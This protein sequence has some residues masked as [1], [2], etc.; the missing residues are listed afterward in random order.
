MV[1]S[2]PSKLRTYGFVSTSYK[3]LLCDFMQMRAFSH[4]TPMYLA[5][6]QPSKL[7]PVISFS[8]LQPCSDL[9]LQFIY[10]PKGLSVYLL[11]VNVTGSF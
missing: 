5:P 3:L 8:L 1:E 11:H 9:P 6:D 2:R 7:D 10:G 4:C